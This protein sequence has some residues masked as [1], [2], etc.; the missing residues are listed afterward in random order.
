MEAV[1]SRIP[2][3]KHEASSVR[4]INCVDAVVNLIEQ[5]NELNWVRGRTLPIVYTRHIR[6][7]RIILLIKVHAIPTRLEVDLCAH[8]VGA[9]R[10][11]HVR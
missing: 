7:V 4:L 8:S 2:I 6:Y 1:P 5:M 3:A 11:Q 9:V 10:I